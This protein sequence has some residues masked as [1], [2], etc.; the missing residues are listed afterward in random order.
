M[1][2]ACWILPIHPELDRQGAALDRALR[3]VVERPSQ[4][5]TGDR[6]LNLPLG[7][8]PEQLARWGVGKEAAVYLYV[9]T[10]AGLHRGFHYAASRYGELDALAARRDR[11]RASRA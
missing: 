7:I 4:T 3:A 5:S 10:R 9:L 6:F 2:N 1:L 8:D 11:R